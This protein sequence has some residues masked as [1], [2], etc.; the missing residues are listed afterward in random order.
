[1]IILMRGQVFKIHSDFYYVNCEKTG[2]LE[3]KVK[4]TLKKQRETVVVGDFVEIEN[5]NTLSKQGFISAI[6][7]RKTFI[8]KPKTANIDQIVIVSAIK[9]PELDFVQL[10]RYI[11]T[12]ELHKIKPILCFNKNDLSSD[13]SIIEKV[14][15]IYEPLGYEIVFISALEETGLEDLEELLA[16]KT[17]ALCGVSGAGKS[18][19]I[20]AL[21][22]GLSIKTAP[23]AEKTKRGTHTTRHLEIFEIEKD[24]KNRIKIVDTPG[25]SYLRFDHIAPEKVSELFPEINVLKPGCKFKDCLHQSE[26]G[27][28]V[29]QNI[30]KI[31]ISRYD[32]YLEFLKE[33]LEAKK[34]PKYT[35]KEAA[36]KELKNKQILKV[37]AKKR[38][39]SRKKKSQELKSLKGK[40]NE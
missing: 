19:L 28:N 20:N 23:V 29:L 26:I 36:T 13:D 5:L 2:I 21:S 30:D 37:S 14:F 3:C 6:H 32:S 39:S 1:M 12:C 35:D 7:P 17:S 34:Q 22:Q 16:S 25:F 31:N 4:D 9:E 10:N 38:E 15:A 18:T 40:E 24:N 11:T 8:L 33:A 27:C